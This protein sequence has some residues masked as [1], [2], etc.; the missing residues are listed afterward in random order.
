MPST[1]PIRLAQRLDHHP[2]GIVSDAA[3]QLAGPGGAIDERPE[4][5]ALQDAA[6]ADQDGFRGP[7]LDGPR[8]QTY[9]RHRLAR[10]VWAEPTTGAML[11]MRI[12]ELAEDLRT[13]TKTL[14]F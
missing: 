10:Q 2:I 1:S 6:D 12:G 5:H 9:S 14:R 7:L 3:A 4:P 8:S 11:H 13:S